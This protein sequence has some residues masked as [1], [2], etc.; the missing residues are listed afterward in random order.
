MK[1]FL[2]FFLVVSVILSFIAIS[3]ESI[4]ILESQEHPQEI[5]ILLDIAGETE[6]KPLV[7][8]HLLE[9]FSRTENINAVLEL[10]EGVS[11]VISVVPVEARVGE[12]RHKTGNIAVCIQYI[13]YFDNS[14]L[15][16][17]V[18]V[19]NWER[20]NNLTTNLIEHSQTGLHLFP[21]D[22]LKKTTSGVVSKFQ[23]LLLEKHK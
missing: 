22:D 8:E 3:L 5:K 19:S 1:R 17:D 4:P 12:N 15:K 18:A 11:Y 10:E 6:L 21:K 16:P 13:S 14:I 9:A 7:Q 2:I 20:V 23:E